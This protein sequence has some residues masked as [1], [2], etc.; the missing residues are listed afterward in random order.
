MEI[1][2]QFYDI[3]INIKILIIIILVII[4]KQI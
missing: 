2:I 1:T 4:N 3:I